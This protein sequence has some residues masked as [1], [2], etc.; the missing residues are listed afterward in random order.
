MKVDIHKNAF[1]IDLEDWFCS[2]NLVDALPIE[3]WDDLESHVEEGTHLLL[4]LL[5]KPGVRATFFVL[6]WVADRFPNLIKD[7]QNAGHEIG[8]HGYAHQQI[9]RISPDDFEVDIRKSL[10]SLAFLGTPIRGYRAPA[11]SL[12]PQT[13]WATDILQKFDFQ[14]DSSVYPLGIH[15]DY[16]FKNAPLTPYQHSNGLMEIPMSVAEFGGLQLPCSGGG[17]LRQLPYPVFRN[18]VRRCNAQGRPLVFYI[19]PWELLPNI[20]KVNLPTLKKWRHYNNLSSTA[21]KITQLL[22]D[23]PFGAM[24]DVFFNKNTNIGLKGA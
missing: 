9:T 5:E 1:T 21:F 7:I 18:L 3:K 20:P 16:G 23:F 13:I 24:E 19:H 8:S 6:G 2:H 10:E 17:Y 14:Y 22:Q 15:P 12:T 11:F 4:N